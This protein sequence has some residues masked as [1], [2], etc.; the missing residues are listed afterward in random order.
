MLPILFFEF[1]SVGPLYLYNNYD[2]FRFLAKQMPW[3]RIVVINRC[4]DTS[5]EHFTKYEHAA[6]LARDGLR[7]LHQAWCTSETPADDFADV[8][9]DILKWM[10]QHYQGEP[11]AIA[12]SMLDANMYPAIAKHAVI[13]GDWIFTED[14]ARQVIELI[15]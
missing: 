7:G 9:P 6:V 4:Y 3:L 10:A 8:G 1:D 12:A 5:R 2:G 14:H 15:G 13:T 11:Y